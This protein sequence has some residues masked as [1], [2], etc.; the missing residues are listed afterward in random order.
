MA[1]LAQ[2][3]IHAVQRYAMDYLF[4]VRCRTWTVVGTI[5]VDG[6]GHNGLEDAERSAH[7]G[8]PEIRVSQKQLEEPGFW[9]EFLQRAR[10]LCLQHGR[11][12]LRLLGAAEVEHEAVRDLRKRQSPPAEG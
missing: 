3:P 8:L 10:Q 2:V 5:E 6:A 1:A 4:A 12:T 9:E 11:P 7:I